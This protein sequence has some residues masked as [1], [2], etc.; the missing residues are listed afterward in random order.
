MLTSGEE[1]ESRAER[2]AHHSKSLYM[3]VKK[4]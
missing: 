4:T 3:M 1:G 2:V